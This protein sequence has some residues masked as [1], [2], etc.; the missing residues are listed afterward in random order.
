MYLGLYPKPLLWDSVPHPASPFQWSS[1][2]PSAKHNFVVPPILA[3]L[4]GLDPKTLRWGFAP[5]VLNRNLS[6]SKTVQWC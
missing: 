5:Y 6:F 2:L 1:I 4:K 3:V